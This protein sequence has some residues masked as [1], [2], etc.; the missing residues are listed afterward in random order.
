MGKPFLFFREYGFTILFIVVFLLSFI[1][2]GTKRTLQ[3]NSNNVEDWL[4]PHVKE[5]QD[6]KWFQKHFPME[7]FVVISWKDCKIADKEGAPNAEDMI[8]AFAQKLVPS[9]TIDNLSNW[10]NPKEV[11]AELDVSEVKGQDSQSPAVKT[12]E[13]SVSVETLLSLEKIAESV[14]TKQEAK[15]VPKQYFKTVLTYPRIKKLL[16]ENSNLTE[17]AI[18]NRLKGTIIGPDGT[19]TALMAYLYEQPK[20]KEAD[21]VIARVHELARELG[22]EPPLAADHS[23]W[24]QKA[25]NTFVEMI[26]EII[27]GRKI[28]LTGVI[29]G[30]TPVDNAAISGEAERTLF[31]LAGFCAVIGVVIAYRCFLSLRLTF[32]VFVTAILSAGISLAI[33]AFTGQRCDAIMLS[34]PALIYVLAMSGAIHLINY[35]HDAIR[36][37]GLKA[38]PERAIKLGWFPCM[39]AALTTA[40]GLI[41]LY[42]S[43][44]PPI[45]KFG[46][47][48]AAGVVM[49][50]TLTFL[51]LP[52]LLYFYPSRKYAEKFGGKGLQS[53][54]SHSIILKIWKFM[55]SKIIRY[56]NG[57]AVFCLAGMVFF[58]VGLFYI[59]PEVKMM[60]FYSSDAPIIQNYTWLEN[61]LGPLVPMEIVLRF[62]NKQCPLSTLQRLRVVDFIAE[63]LRGDA[64]TEIG[65]VMSA[66]TMMPIDSDPATFGKIRNLRFAK[67]KTVSS[68]LDANRPLFKDFIA[69]ELPPDSTLDKLGLSDRDVAW[70][71]GNGVTGIQT[72][73]DIPEGTAFHGIKAEELKPFRDAA[74]L[75]Q[76]ENGIDLW[77]INLRVWA[78]AHKDID[79]S[80]LIK[81]IHAA[82]T[83]YLKPEALKE[84]ADP[85][86]DG[87]NNPKFADVNLTGVD[88]VYTGMVP[89][90]YQTQHQLILGLINSLILAFVSIAVVFCL[91]LKNPVAGFLAMV[92]NV[93][94][95]AVVF[96]FM[97]WNRTL[98]DVGT[99][100]TASVAL[101]VAVDNT[102][103]YLTWFR[104]SVE[105]GLSPKAAA[106]EAYE[107]CATAMTESTLIGGLGLSAF[108]FSTFT[109]TKMFG[110]MMLAILS[111]SL[112]GDMIFLPAIL[113]GPLGRFF[114]KSAKKK[115]GTSVK[116]RT[117]QRGNR[118]VNPIEKVL[119]AKSDTKHLSGVP[120]PEMLKEHES[121]ISDYE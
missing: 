21:R 93:F 80:E 65:G 72:L 60:K 115:A 114:L 116:N 15:S 14:Q 66:A 112:I 118:Q 17:E 105:L 42:T 73:L 90:V 85:L 67:E 106:L 53:E 95:V 52:A 29:I 57:V 43:N 44:L 5:T 9:Q 111:V 102:M 30:G 104:K 70:L 13:E 97:G 48:S 32:F 50:L 16:M 3:S 54:V 4:P 101:G 26:Q 64:V 2:M 24:Y 12:Q 76:K 39:I 35:Y 41:S 92:P 31:R 10:Y 77:R 63:E 55:G 120:R 7:S 58:S 119:S 117:L 45:R 89:L 79:Y 28:D 56:H 82:V 33:V 47:Y 121:R 84:I 91:I 94:P 81:V 59:K 18:K 61:Q 99:M 22:L 38:A 96:G 6:Y 110:I 20:G 100:M 88:A 75:W 23:A 108:M 107:R 49:S 34:M 78:L 46:I 36:E 11:V 62:D 113:T 40:F 1:W 25:G 109:P 86:Q 87:I 8:E 51:F 83:N 103:H 69:T 19:S 37:H 74:R 71:Q 98:V 27:Y 68:V